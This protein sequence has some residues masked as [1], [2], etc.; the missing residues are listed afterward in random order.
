MFYVYI[1]TL[2]SLFSGGLT[3]TCLYLFGFFKAVF[4]FRR[5]FFVTEKERFAVN[6]SE[7]NYGTALLPISSYM[8][9]TMTFAHI[10][11]SRFLFPEERQPLCLLLYLSLIFKI[12][13]KKGFPENFSLG[14]ALEILAFSG[15]KR[16]YQNKKKVYYHTR[17]FRHC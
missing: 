16:A 8:R 17:C 15:R 6:H 4:F 12:N 7:T 14:R 5:F 1:H 11:Q 13:G 2:T 3:F 10:R 9:R